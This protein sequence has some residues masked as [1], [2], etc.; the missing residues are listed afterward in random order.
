MQYSP[1]E[2]ANVIDSRVV[3][4]HGR[5]VLVIRTTLTLDESGD[6]FDRVAINDLCTAFAS[7][8][9]RHP[10]IMEGHLIRVRH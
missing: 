10:G 1:F 7:Y 9:K 6:G 4:H 2:H 3:E 8:A 5:R